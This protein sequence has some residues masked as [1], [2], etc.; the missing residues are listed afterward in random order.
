M[1]MPSRIITAVAILAN[2]AFLVLFVLHPRVAFAGLPRWARVLSSCEFCERPATTYLTYRDIGSGT[3]TQIGLCAQHA[4]SPPQF[5]TPGSSKLFYILASGF[6]YIIGAIALIGYPLFVVFAVRFGS[7]AERA[8]LLSAMFGTALSLIVILY[9][10]ETL[11][12]E[13]KMR[14]NFARPLFWTVL[15]IGTCVLARKLEHVVASKRDRVP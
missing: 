6:L 1:T 2:C 10:R 8:Q 12:A 15:F 11:V 7:K 5:L 4:N 9:A 14:V 13:L 3:T